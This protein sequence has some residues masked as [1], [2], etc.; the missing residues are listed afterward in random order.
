MSTTVLTVPVG[1]GALVAICAI[2]GC[3]TSATLL[4]ADCIQIA[5]AG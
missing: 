4:S 3:A 1:G 2:V 5:D